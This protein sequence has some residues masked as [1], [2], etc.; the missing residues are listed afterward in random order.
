MMGKIQQND[1]NTIP[2]L[3]SGFLLNGGIIWSLPVDDGK[4]PFFPQRQ[5][6]LN[7]RNCFTAA[8]STDLVLSFLLWFSE[9]RLIREASTKETELKENILFPARWGTKSFVFQG[10]VSNFYEISL[11]NSG[12]LD[13]FI[14]KKFQIIPHTIIL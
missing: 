11:S 6:Y 7:T 2:L 8:A 14:L 1:R 3:F 13:T 4:I 5:Y 9:F 10:A 12:T